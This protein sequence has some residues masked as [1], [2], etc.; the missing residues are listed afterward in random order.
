MMSN[1]RRTLVRLLTVV[2]GLSAIQCGSS[3]KDHMP[4]TTSSREAEAEFRSGRELI[5]NVRLHDAWRHFQKAVKSDPEF[6]LAFLYLAYSDPSARGFFENLQL[7]KTH[8]SHISQGEQLLI[9]SALAYADGNPGRQRELLGKLVEMYPKDECVL[10]FWAT[11]YFEQQMYDSAAL[12]CERIVQLAPSY[13]SPYN[14]LG[15]SY[16]ALGNLDAAARAFQ[17]YIRLIP[18]DP[19][20]YDSYAEL[21]THM[22]HFEEA[23]QQYR[24]ALAQDPTFGA[25]RIG[26]SA[27]L[28]FLGRYDEARKELALL[29]DSAVNTAHRRAALIGIVVSYIDEG[30]L[31]E[32]L[33]QLEAVYQLDA[34]IPDPPSMS[35]D[36]RSIAYVLARLG[37]FEEAESRL[38]RALDVIES[39]NV[40][41][42]V[43]RDAR[44][45]QTM[46][47]AVLR[48]EQGQLG[49]AQ[50]LA[51][52]YLAEISSTANPNRLR[53]AH[54]VRGRVALSQGDYDR[55]ITELEHAD[56][57]QAWTLFHLAQAYEGKGDLT[58]A[59]ELYENAAKSYEINSMLYAFIRRQAAG[60]ADELR[61]KL[62]P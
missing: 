55:A 5:N 9:E 4:V 57:Q 54:L 25:S 22:G 12:V 3:D 20:P 44:T 7:A 27:N 32:A 26:I 30:E 56:Q 33:S 1:L 6:A 21:L 24:L 34:S 18:K 41:D 50:A 45:D 10:L 17:E 2:A 46:W 15:Y 38:H 29:R 39:S 48:L 52:R 31:S 60:K 40:F 11:A 23:I 49:E 43:K 58:K 47:L 19:N 37:Q 8:L 62:T 59:V 28:I 36:L 61:Q 16:R 42:R 35:S 53:V 13:A 14:I 51:D